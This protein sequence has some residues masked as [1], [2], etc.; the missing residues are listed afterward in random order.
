M[1]DLFK[2][3]GVWIEDEATEPKAGDII[4]YDWEDSGK[5][6]NKGGANHVGICEKVNKT[7]KEFTVIEGNYD[8]SVKRRT[9]KFNGKYLRGLARPKYDVKAAVN[10]VD[11]PVNKSIEEVA[12][13]VIKGNYGNGSERR[14]NLEAAGY[15]YSQVQAAVNQLLYG[16]KKEYYAVKKGDT[17][18][19][20]AKKYNTT[21]KQLAE[22]NNIK[23]VNV[24]KIG[25][26][27]RVK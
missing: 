15:N 7:K 13:D 5:G 21:V 2:N 18:S 23:D 6:D 14:K 11:K 27:L 20:I 3:I 12:A 4:F 24:I 16:K 17:L 9:L 1:I 19:G 25:Q 26:K 10:T 8:N 22:W